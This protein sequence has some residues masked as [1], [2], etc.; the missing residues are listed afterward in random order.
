[1]DY[2]GKDAQEL[3]EKKL[4][5]LDMDGTIYNEDKLIEGTLD[6]L[7]AIKRNGG[8]YVFITNNSSRSRD[9]YVSK[10]QRLG[11]EAD[12]ENFFT[13]GQLAAMMLKRD[14][15]GK[16]VYCQGTKSLVGG[17][18][19]EGITV[20]EEVEDDIDVILVGFDTEVTGRKLRNTSELL[21]TRDL[22]Y[23]ATNCDLRC[24]VS[25]GYIPDCGSMC[26]ALYN[27]TGKKPVYLGKPEPEMIYTAMERYGYTGDETA[28]VG[29]RI[30]TDIPAGVRA[31]VATICVLTGEAGLADIEASPEKPDYVFDSVRSVCKEI[32]TIQ[33]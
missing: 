17:L 23:Y 19:D 12:E 26:Q 9:D 7:D 30:Y 2:N 22:P 6:F 1:M 10:V 21:I 27:T 20:T 24:P 13:S 18:R 5:L 11:I 29:D 8:K 33:N 3:K 16:K 31:G 15:P 25:F 4:W 32:W 28:V 14:Y